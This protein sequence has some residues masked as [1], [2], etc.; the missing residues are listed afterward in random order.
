V[1][2]AKAGIEM[3]K[4]DLEQVVEGEQTYWLSPAAQVAKGTSPSAHLMQPYD[5][6]FIAY[7]DRSALLRR[8]PANQPTESTFNS[9][10]E[11]D[12]QVVGTWKRSVTRG[13]V[14]IETQYATVLTDA[15]MEAVAAAAV[16]YGRFVGRT[17]NLV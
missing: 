15:E 5:E 14:D 17:A 12:G 3:V 6:Y 10:I 13:R 2:E 4:S 1:A 8:V 7:K 11:L 16:A 9:V